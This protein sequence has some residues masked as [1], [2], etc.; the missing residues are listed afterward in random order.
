VSLLGLLVA[1]MG[2]M[3]C[4]P[5]FAGQDIVL[6][7][8]DTLRRDVVSAYGSPHGWTPEIDSLARQGVVVERAFS[9]APWTRPSVGSLFT[10]LY[11]ARHEAVKNDETSSLRADVSTLAEVLGKAGYATFAYVTNANLVEEFGFARGFEHYHFTLNLWARS[12]NAEALRLLE[13][14]DW[15]EGRRPIFIV[16]HY[17]EPHTAF[18]TSSFSQSIPGGSRAGMLRSMASLDAVARIAAIER[19]GAFVAEVDRRVGEVVGALTGRL[20]ENHLIILTSDHGEE[21]FDHGAAFHGFTLY[22]ELLSVPLILSSPRLDP[23]RLTGPVRNIDLLP[24]IC[25]WTGVECPRGLDGRSYARALLG[26]GGFRGEVVAETEYDRRLQSIQDVSFKLIRDKGGDEAVLFDLKSDPGELVD[27]SEDFAG[28]KRR[29]M[30]RLD[31]TEAEWIRG[32]ARESGSEAT[33]SPEEQEQLR[34]QLRSLGYLGEGEEADDVWPPGTRLDW[35]ELYREYAFLGPSDPRIVY[36]PGPWRSAGAHHA[37]RVVSGP[38]SEGRIRVTLAFEEAH[39]VFG[40]GRRCGIAEV[41]LDGESMGEFDLHLQH[42]EIGQRIVAVEASAGDH[43]LEVLATG[44]KH[45]DAAASEVRFEGIILRRAEPA[46]G[47]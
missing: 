3:A 38:G 5:P 27:R 6:I 17:M 8:I 46:H 18:F 43:T 37:G 44:R 12:V 34:E 47:R 11:P 41:L 31:E 7:N 45:P 28:P 24:T 13:G 4:Q 15:S 20:S 19:Y 40:A 16:L 22:N 10:G 25:D 29:L 42:P 32:S 2:L 26:R 1:A 30:E 23:A 9:V 33:A 39:L 14:L 36:E 21:W 35:R